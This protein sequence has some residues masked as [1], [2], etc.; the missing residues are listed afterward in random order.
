MRAEGLV[1]RD[2][3]SANILI[4]KDGQIRLCDLGFATEDC[5]LYEDKTINVGSPLYMAPEV[6][7]GN[8]YSAKADIWALGLVLLEMLIGDF[9][10]SSA[11]FN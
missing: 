7:K 8:E 4:G 3:K 11:S 10:W 6:I 1:H 9:P 5:F 2:I